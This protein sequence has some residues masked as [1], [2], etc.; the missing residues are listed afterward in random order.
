MDVL[1]PLTLLGLILVI[2][3]IA[4]L[5]LPLLV[6]AIPEISL[7]Q[8]KKYHPYLLYVYEGDNFFVIVPVPLLVAGLLYFIWLLFK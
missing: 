5:A 4:L 3:G 7:D 6:K 8:L 2:I 1:S